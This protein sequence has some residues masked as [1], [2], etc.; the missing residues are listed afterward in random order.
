MRKKITI[1]VI[2]FAT[3][4]FFIFKLA[5]NKKKINEKNMPVTVKN[6]TIPVTVAMV[7]I[8]TEQSK[9]MKTGVLAPIAQSKVLSVANGNIKRLQFKIGD[10]V[11]KGQSLAIIDTKLLE[12][13]LQK[14]STNLSKLKHDLQVYTELLEGK[15]TTTERVS[16]IRLSYNDALAQY[17]QL[18]R[19]IADATIKAPTSGIVASKIVE[20]GMFVMSGAE[21]ATIVN[22]EKLKVEVLLT[23]TEVYKI[24]VGQRI[25]LKT[26]VYPE[27]PFSGRITFIAPQADQTYNYKVEITA[28]NDEKF[29]LRS[30]TFTYADFSQPSVKKIMLIPRDA[31]MTGTS[32]GSVYVIENGRASLKKIKL[33]G[34][35]GELIEVISGLIPGEQVITSG[36]INLKDG[37]LVN[38]SK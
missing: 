4:F 37:T 2:C 10:H 31:L 6:V 17:Q 13:D 1:G 15:A 9:L 30:G 20:E 18:R 27:R 12:L 22:L 35:Y 14:S 26:D 21:I 29:P 36:Q 24:S 34:T 33:G 11:I 32:D 5:N 8:L 28:T 23:E 7:K 38:V 16:E 19:Q 3:I 25:I